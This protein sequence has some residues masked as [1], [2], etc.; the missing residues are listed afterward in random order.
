MLSY[1]IGLPRVRNTQELL[2]ILYAMH[3]CDD[4]YKALHN[5]QSCIT[6]PF[7]IKHVHP[8]SQRKVIDHDINWFIDWYTYFIYIQ[9]MSKWE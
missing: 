7:Y 5:I 2:H 4:R 8:T 9:Y 6:E 3:V 1:S